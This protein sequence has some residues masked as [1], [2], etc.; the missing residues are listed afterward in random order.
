MS[1]ATEW[2]EPKKS[3]GIDRCA[4][5]LMDVIRGAAS[6]VVAGVHAFQVFVLPYFGTGGA[7]HLFSSLMATYAVL[8][9]FVVSGFMISV[10]VMGHR[11]TGSFDWRSFLVARVLRI[12]PPLL[13]AIGISALCYWII[14]GLGLHGSES[15]HLAGD[16]FVVR[17]RAE[18]TLDTVL[19]TLLLSYGTFPYSP[20]PISMDGSLWTL[21]YEFWFYIICM[22]TLNIKERRVLAGVIPGIILFALIVMGNN[23]L[24]FMFLLVWTAGYTLGRIYQQGWLDGPSSKRWL[25]LTACVSVTFVVV[26]GGSE[27]AIKLFDPYGGSSNQQILAAVGIVFTA[28]LGLALKGKARFN[29]MALRNAAGYSYTLYVLHWPLY[30]LAFSLLHPVLHEFRWE[31]SLLV[32]VVVFYSV[33]VA[34]SI[35]ARFVEDR[36]L[37]A[38]LL[39]KCRMVA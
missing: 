31:I 22:L 15:F 27:V 23:F 25:V 19:A 5:E 11:R 30:L 35:L 10:S 8:V 20:P 7:I 16:L 34:S 4:S 29:I 21:G 36:Y 33:I 12:Y 9:F 14:I 24:Q 37:F 3:V 2:T 6:L 28:L 32:S 18:M 13:T 26:V 17:E 38:R 1:Y 39:A